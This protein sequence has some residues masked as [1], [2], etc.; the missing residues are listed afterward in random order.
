MPS[1]AVSHPVIDLIRARVRNK[2]KP[3]Q[4]QDPHRIALAIEGGGLRGVVTAGMLLGMEQL[5]V[6][7]A[8]DVVYGASAG[9]TNAAFY[10]ATQGAF[11]I[12]CYL[13]QLPNRTF[14]S[15]YRNLVG[16]PVVN[17][18]YLY[19]TVIIENVPLD[20]QAVVSS[21][22]PL[23]VLATSVSGACTEIFREFSSREDLAAALHASAS[24]PFLAHP[25]PF[26]YRERRYWDGGLLD[27]FGIRTAIAE[28]NSHILVLR[29][30]PEGKPLREMNAAEVRLLFPILWSQ[31]PTLA[32]KVLA[33]NN[34]EA[35]GASLLIGSQNIAANVGPPY[36]YG[37]AVDSSVPE[38]R[39][40]DTNRKHLVAGAA[41]G[42]RAVFE[43]FGVKNSSIVQ[44]LAAFD[45][46]G[47]RLTSQ[48]L[49]GDS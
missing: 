45:R 16:R 29:S 19:R 14:I 36:L 3:G 23:R 33:A 47:H 44:T 6:K 26:I 35:N 28:N 5:E 12:T 9:S 27:L 37:V 46:S 39:R 48:H 32:R 30:R 15:F 2:S 21:P 22:I 13:D 17:L 20:W 10:L 41:A 40:M 7:D 24:V 31:S 25:T 34:P 42:M 49:C 4:R 8:F 38:I 43:T 18:D 1:S 11:G